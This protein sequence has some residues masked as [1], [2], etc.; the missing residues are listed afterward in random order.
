MTDVKDKT[1]GDCTFQDLEETIQDME[2]FRV[3]L[4]DFSDAAT[5]AKISLNDSLKALMTRTGGALSTA[6]EEAGVFDRLKLSLD[7]NLIGQ[8][9]LS[10]P[11]FYFTD[12][13]DFCVRRICS[14][15]GGEFKAVIK[16]IPGYKG[17]GDC[18][19]LPH[20]LGAIY[21]ICKKTG[22]ITDSTIHDL[23]SFLYAE[24]GLFYLAHRAPSWEAFYASLFEIMNLPGRKR[25][26]SLGEL[27]KPAPLGGWQY[28]HYHHFSGEG[29]P[30]RGE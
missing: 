25:E 28:H 1:G 16:K 10:G 30:L 21:K 15:D 6:L 4:S 27:F 11:P 13:G 19:I 26:K 18:E 24:N 29:S 7:L 17:W 8:G 23:C 9:L 20:H 5:S 22:R 12:R 14:Y 3:R 2:V